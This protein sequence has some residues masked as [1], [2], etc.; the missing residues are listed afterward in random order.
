[1]NT[2]A[3]SGD[4]EGSYIMVKR[5]IQQ[6]DT[7]IRSTYA[8]NIRSPKYIKQILLDLK[9]EFENNTMNGLQYTTFNNE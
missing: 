1:M 7:A 6:E 9:E 4:E 5:S 2:K 8:P 3:I